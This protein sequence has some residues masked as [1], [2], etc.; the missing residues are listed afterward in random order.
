MSDLSPAQMRQI[1]AA[2]YA[3]APSRADRGRVFAGLRKHFAVAS[4]RDIP[5]EKLGDVLRVISAYK[6]A[7]DAPAPQPK[8]KAQPKPEPAAKPA[9]PADTREQRRKR[10]V[11]GT[12]TA[13]DIVYDRLV[14][15]VCDDERDW[16]PQKV[17]RALDAMS[18]NASIL[19]AWLTLQSAR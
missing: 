6:I 12:F 1:T 11:L 5:A 7:K 16:P 18:E 19:E 14:D 15:L 13:F 3:A 8:P 4:Y 17:T 9:K 2:V 10:L